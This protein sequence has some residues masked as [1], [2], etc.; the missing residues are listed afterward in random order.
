[1]SRKNI[2]IILLFFIFS[3]TLFA[4]EAGSAPSVYIK[5]GEAKLKK[6]LLAFPPIQFNGSAG[7]ARQKTVGNEIFNTI[8]NDLE[9]SSYFQFI[10]QDAFLEDTSKTSLRPTPVETNG[11][12]FDS[13]KQIGAEF[14][15]RSGFN[16]IG[17]Q[18]ELETYV[19]FVPSQKLVFGKKYTGSVSSARKMA[20]IFSN[21]VLEKLTGKK[22]MFLSKLTVASDMGGGKFKE[23]YVMDWDGYNP[24]KITAHKSIALSPSWAP[25]YKT[26]VYTA[27]AFHTKS[28]ARNV[29][30]FSYELDTK[31][32]F[33]LS[34]RKGINSGATFTP[35]GKSLLLTVSQSGTPDIYR[36]SLDG[37]QLTPLARGP[38]S[39]MNVEPSPSPKGD[40]IAFSSDRSGQPMIYVMNSDGTNV[41]RVTFAGRYNASPSWSPDGTKIAFAGY[42]KT[43]FDIFVMDVNGLNLERLTSAK[44]ANGKMADNEDPTFSPDGRHIMF[45]SNRTGTHQIYIMNIDGTNERRVTVD[46][47]NYFRPKWSGF[48][49]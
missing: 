22:G 47:A 43:H 33:L 27:F 46:R 42:D 15:I 8:T 24:Q 2:F 28:K 32:R 11:F 10:K 6:S 40:R 21:D 3:P 31:K 7:G 39:A 30:L 45:T 41:K 37:T 13:W 26:I 14:L 23:I 34:S 36:M 38:G 18:I 49:E 1:M 16:L 35:D 4:Q 9:F 12:K 20:H 25:D 48:L 44:K 19:Y 5:I 29:D 17:N